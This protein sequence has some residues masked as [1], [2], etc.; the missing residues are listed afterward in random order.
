MTGRARQVVD[1]RAL[2]ARYLLNSYSWG[3]A[4]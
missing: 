4:G 1:G 2:R 3:D